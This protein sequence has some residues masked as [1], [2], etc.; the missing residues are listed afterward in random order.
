[1]E[2][3]FLV[4]LIIPIL[5]VLVLFGLFFM[6]LVDDICI[7]LFGR[8]MFI[9]FYFW[10]QDISPGQEYLLRQKLSFYQKLDA[11]QK[12]YFN[13]RVARF[14]DKYQI[15]GRDG[16]L[17]TQEVE[18]LIAATY[19]MLTFG[20]RRFLVDTFDKIIV[21]P[22]VYLSTQTQEYYKGEFNPRMKAVVFSWEDFVSGYEISNDNLN[23]GIHEFSHVIH[24]HSLNRN[25]ASSL[26]FKKHHAQLIKEVNH[27]PNMQ[28]LIDSDYFR[29]YAYTNHY[30]F[31]SVIIEHFFESPVEF[32]RRFPALYLNVSRMLNHPPV[33]LHR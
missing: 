3:E 9:H 21:Y 8:P 27:P 33:S 5:S 14:L 19:V 26:A 25:D 32:H 29:I 20:M 2:G 24:H 30:E 23:L 7:A 11:K 22:E 6:G 13:H 28:M 1:M 12:T 31:I 10:K 16:F 4:V 15:I 18:T 17:V